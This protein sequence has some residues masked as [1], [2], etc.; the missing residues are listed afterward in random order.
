MRANLNQLL[1]AALVTAF[2]PIARGQTFELLHSFQNSDG[3]NPRAGLVQGRDNN[4][5]GT[6]YNGG[7]NG[8]TN[9]TVFR[10]TPAGSLTTLITFTNTNGAL[11]HAGLV[12]GADGDLY[13]TTSAG[14]ANY[15]NS[16]TVFKITTNGVLTTLVSFDYWS[17]G[18]Y[19]YAKVVQGSNGNFYGTTLYGGANLRGTVFKMT[20]TGNLTTLVAFNG[21]TNGAGP[22][23]ELVQGSDGNFYGTTAGGAATFNDVATVFRMRPDGELTTLVSFNGR[24]PT[25]GLVRASDGDFYGTSFG[26]ANGYGRVIKMTPTGELATLASFVSYA[27]TVGYSP[28]AGLLQGNDRSFY[29]T[30]TYGG[31]GYAGTVFKMTPNG[32]LSALASFNG[33]NG[34]YPYAGLVQGND[35]NLYGTTS[36]GGTFGYGTVF[37]IVMPVALNSQRSGNEFVLSWPT[38]AVGYTLQ[39][40]TNLVPPV[41]WSDSTNVPVTVGAEFRVTNTLS[42]P[43]QFYRLKK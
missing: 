33:S 22:T 1:A 37:R 17:N 41:G 12:E 43:I 30:T 23:A 20:P 15:G 11:P 32:D 3:A 10:I 25:S 9:G 24:G 18:G 40:A 14:G 29:G 4:F 19:P 5:Y 34:A 38:N 26:G 36:Q 13:G 2:V 7:A 42:C 21:D 28:Y 35:G 8:S 16:G 6:T 39:V 27:S 31:T